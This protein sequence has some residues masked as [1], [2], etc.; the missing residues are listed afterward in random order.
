M[1][2]CC[3]VQ[4]GN[5]AGGGSALRWHCSAAC[6]RRGCCRRR[7]RSFQIRFFLC[8]FLLL[9]QLVQLLLCD[10]LLVPAGAQSGA[11]GAEL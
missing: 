3:S 4:Q 9:R 8:L 10:V 11:G 5:A 7:S 2:K 6:F 1:L